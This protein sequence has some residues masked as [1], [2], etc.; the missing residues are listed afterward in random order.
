MDDKHDNLPEKNNGN[1]SRASQLWYIQRGRRNRLLDRWREIGWQQ[2]GKRNIV[3]IQNV[4]AKT[5]NEMENEF[6]KREHRRALCDCR[7]KITIGS[8]VEN[9]RSDDKSSPKKNKMRSKI[10]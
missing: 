2:E 6:E 5:D 7:K 10:L 8:M 9:M 1:G 3:F 4:W